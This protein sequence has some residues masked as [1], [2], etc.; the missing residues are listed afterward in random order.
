LVVVVDT[1]RARVEA[2]AW[3]R[4]LEICIKY[5]HLTGLKG[6]SQILR[7]PLCPV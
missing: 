6:G 5:T 3:Q 4:R 1:S 7:I 2:Q